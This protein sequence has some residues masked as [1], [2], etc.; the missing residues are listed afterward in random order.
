MTAIIPVYSQGSEN[1][2][3]KPQKVDMYTLGDQ[4]FSI[5]AGLFFPLFF[6]DLTPESGSSAVAS[7]NLSVGGTGSLIY[8]AYL[9]NHLKVGAE[10]GGMFAY[11]PNS[12]PFFMVPITARIGYEFHF[13]QFSM[14]IYM[15]T[16]INIITY[17]DDTNVQFLLKPGIS[18]YWNYTS[19]W[20]FGGNLVYWF[21]PEIVTE[22]PEH[23]RI[24]NFLDFTISAQYHF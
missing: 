16:G 12:N 4:S 7:T 23:D 15:G 8:E 9:N 1:D 5:N 18:L 10:V 13:G 6:L 11:S 2:E 3:P 20:S 21:S 17:D 19:D 22:N 24:G 14:P